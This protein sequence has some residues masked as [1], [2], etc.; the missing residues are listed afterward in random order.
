MR[1]LYSVKNER[2]GITFKPANKANP[3]SSTALITCVCR[4]VLCNLSASKLRMAWAAGIIFVPG[5]PQLPIPRLKPMAAIAGRNKNRP[6][7]FVCTVRGSSD[8]AR[9]SARSA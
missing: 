7:N 8:R 1:Q 9:A 3:S 2:L 5:K 4:A 6:P